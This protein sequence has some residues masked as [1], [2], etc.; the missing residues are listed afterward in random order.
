MAAGITKAAG[1]FLPLLI[2]VF[3]SCTFSAEGSIGSSDTTGSSSGTGTASTG[4]GTATELEQA[5]ITEMNLART[6]PRDYVTQR[7]QPLVSSSSGSYLAALNECIS[8]MNSMAAVG[9]LSFGNGLYKAAKE[10]VDTQGAGT[11]TGHDTNLYP[12][13]RKYCSYTKAGENLAY[14]YSTAK[15]IVVALLVDNGVQDRGHRKN[16][17]DKDYTH[18]GVSIGSHGRYSTMCCMDFAGG[19]SD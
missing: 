18:V 2:L 1:L 12:R 8:Q 5:V 3:A 19:Y 7:L 13:I 10:W 15:D 11:S 16:I 4:A 17:L 6:S 9:S 14:G